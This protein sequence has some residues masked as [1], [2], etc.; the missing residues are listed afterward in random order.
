VS[1][2]PGWMDGAIRREVRDRFD[3]AATAYATSR[4]GYP[5]AAVNWMLGAGPRDILDLAAGS[6]SLTRSLRR[7]AHEVVAADASRHLLRE[8]RS[9]EASIPVVQ[10]TAES[11]PFDDA[12]F[13]VV[14]V[15]TAFHWFEPARV[16]PEIARVL[17]P[18]GHLA[19]VWNTR[20]L[21]EPW[22]YR[23]DDLLR[24]VQ[25]RGLH[26][27]WGVESAQVLDHS[28]W[29]D[30]PK[31]AVFEHEQVVDRAG[32]LTLVRSRSYVIALAERHRVALLDQVGDLFDTHAAS[33]QTLALPYRT[34][35]FRSTVRR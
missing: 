14:T 26:G 24:D 15:A 8:L 32:L 13:D 31:R 28:R 20:H 6:G 34:E 12:T 9:F 27:D 3:E 17:R 7:R 29:F 4:P 11:L 33:G 5:D 23:L 1:A 16:L 18:G 2:A 30:P 10:T 22:T 25:P 21:A 35:C 19:L